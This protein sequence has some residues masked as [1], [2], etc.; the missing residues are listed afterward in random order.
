MS[1]ADYLSKYLSGSD[2]KSGKKKLKK[3]KKHSQIN[4]VATPVVIAGTLATSSL[5]ALKKEEET[6]Q[7][8]EESEFAPTRLTNVPVIKENKGFRRVGD[9]SLVKKEEPAVSQSEQL[10]QPET[11]YRDLSGRIFDVKKRTAELK[12]EQERKEQEEREA[13]EKIAS[14]ELDK[15]RQEKHLQAVSGAKRFDYSTNDQEYI[16]HMKAKTQFDDP[17]SAFDASIK[18]TTPAASETGRPVYTKGLAPANRF[19]IKPGFF[20]DG[21]DRSSGFE[22]RLVKKRSEMHVEKF[23]SK[24]AAESYTEYDFE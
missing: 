1:R 10:E 16:D 24:A 20:W 23:T 22:D 5:D 2:D 18:Q 4:S 3:T 14:G 8:D 19:K 21:I 6:S 13:K 11:I 9:G 12:A 7:V 17:L 15:V